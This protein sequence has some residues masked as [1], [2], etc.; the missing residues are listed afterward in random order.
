MCGKN[1]IRKGVQKYC[2]SYKRK[3]GC[4]W[5][6]HQERRREGFIKWKNKYPDREKK[7][8]KEQDLKKKIKKQS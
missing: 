1:E 8:N 4:S 5:L 7:H 6:K 2:G 3:E